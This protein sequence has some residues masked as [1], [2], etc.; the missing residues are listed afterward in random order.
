MEK[1][2]NYQNNLD[3]GL[4]I[5]FEWISTIAVRMR[6]DIGMKATALL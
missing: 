4:Q 6:K 3:N 5:W 2:K 1:Y